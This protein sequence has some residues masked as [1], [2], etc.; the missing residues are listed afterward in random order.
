VCKEYPRVGDLGQVGGA[1]DGDALL[2]ASAEVGE[3]SSEGDQV[4]AVRDDEDAVG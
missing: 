3:E 1:V 4:S 2:G